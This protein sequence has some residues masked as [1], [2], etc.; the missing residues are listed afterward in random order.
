LQKFIPIRIDPRYG[1][2]AVLRTFYDP[3]GDDL[4]AGKIVPP[5]SPVFA[6]AGGMDLSRYAIYKPV[7]A[8]VSNES[9]YW[10]LGLGFA[11]FPNGAG[12]ASG[13]SQ[14][15]IRIYV[16]FEGEREGSTEGVD[17]RGELAR[18]DPARPWQ[19][20]ITLDGAHPGARLRSFDGKVDRVIK[21]LIV[22]QSS[23]LYVH[24]P[25]DIP[26]ARAILT[27]R[28]NWHYVLI[29][30]YDPYA[31]GN[32]M[33]IKPEASMGNAGGA[34]SPLTPKL[35]DVLDAPGH[36]QTAE[37]S[38]FSDEKNELACLYPVVFDGNEGGRKVD[39]A[40]LASAAQKEELEQAARSRKEFM[41]MTK[42]TDPLSAARAYYFLGDKKQADACFLR[43]LESDPG[44]PSA[45]AFRGAIRSADGSGAAN[46][47]Q[48]VIAVQEGFTYLDKAVEL[49][50]SSGQ[51]N[52]VMDALTCRAEVCVA[53]PE[54]VFGKSAVGATDFEAVANLYAVK[55]P[56]VA[57]EARAWVRAALAW[58][59]AGNE[60][61]AV[62]DYLRA[63]SCPARDAFVENELALAGLP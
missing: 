22:P 14:P 55:V 46:P 17:A 35:F 51:E 21:T 29:G 59:R 9:P 50:R 61:R 23:S 1:G 11:A 28:P 39:Y 54:A 36:E 56:R 4:G 15:E 40:A 10:Q 44:N 24:L 48:A 52:C 27:G 37:L 7:R 41:A 58:K 19:L 30:A 31:N 18:F 63:K 38:S 33:P 6:E 12:Y 20:A 45:L 62:S 49:A 5:L 3:V 25:L 42:G 32:L 26:Q 2:G 43:I 34:L 13:F 8:P 16:G 53:I 57:D 60:S 47:A